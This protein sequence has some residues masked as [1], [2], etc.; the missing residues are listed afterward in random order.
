MTQKWSAR[1][2]SARHNPSATSCCKPRVILSRIVKAEVAS[3]RPPNDG[4]FKAIYWQF[5]PLGD[6][7]TYTLTLT[8]HAPNRPR[9]T[10]REAYNGQ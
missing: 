1:A 4:H 2:N 8:N 5:A 3:S 9:Q 10:A 7:V 6:L